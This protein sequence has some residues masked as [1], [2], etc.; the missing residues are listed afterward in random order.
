MGSTDY[1]LLAVRPSGQVTDTLDHVHE[2]KLANVVVGLRFEKCA[3]P[4]VLAGHLSQNAVLFLR[5][6]GQRIDVVVEMVARGDE[7][8]MR[9]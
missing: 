1:V 5:P 2:Q 9:W 8:H 6:L 3:I 7:D 4:V